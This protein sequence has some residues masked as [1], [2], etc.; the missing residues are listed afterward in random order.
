LFVKRAARYCF[1]NFK[2]RA[3]QKWDRQDNSK[4]VHRKVTVL[5]D[6]CERTKHRSDKYKQP[7]R[8]IAKIENT[9]ELVEIDEA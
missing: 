5:V 2:T 9:Y 1:G 6:S 3:L 7:V 8:H 4:Q